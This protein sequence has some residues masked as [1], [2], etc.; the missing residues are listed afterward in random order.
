MTKFDYKKNPDEG[1]YNEITEAVKANDNYCPCSLFKNE[2]TKCMCTEFREE[3]QSGF[4]H[5]GRFYKVKDFP[6]IAIIHATEDEAHALKLASGLTSEGFIAMLPLY[7]GTLNY[8]KNEETYTEL[9]H[10][11]IHLADLVF[12]VNS[13]EEAVKEIEEQILWAEELHKKIIYE[14]T[15]EVK[16]DECI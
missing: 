11:K 12:V 15:E 13:S 7:G 1:A 9:Q 10:T 2:D 6:I 3:E 5:C 16:E 4:C 8:L 14:Y